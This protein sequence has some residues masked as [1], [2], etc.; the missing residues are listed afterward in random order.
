MSLARMKCVQNTEEQ[1]VVVSVPQI[2]NKIGDPAYSESTS[3][4]NIDRSSRTADSGAECRSAESHPLSRAFA[5]TQWS[6]MY[7]TLRWSL[8][9]RE[10]GKDCIDCQKSVRSLQHTGAAHRHEQSEGATDCRSFT[11]TV[12]GHDR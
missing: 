1:R 9:S 8:K 10:T 7:Q 3:I 6:T 11:A 4:L 12:H 2:W 5:S